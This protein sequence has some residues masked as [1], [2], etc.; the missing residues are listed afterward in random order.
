MNN[1]FVVGL[2][3][4]YPI[5]KPGIFDDMLYLLQGFS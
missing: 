4:Y 3:G 1:P 2:I 5:N